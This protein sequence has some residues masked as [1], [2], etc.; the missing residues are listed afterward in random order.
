MRF[1]PPDRKPPTVSLQALLADPSKASIFTG[2][3][4]FV[5]VTAQTEHD[6]L[7]TPYSEGVPTNGIE[8][9]ADAFE[10]MAQ[11]LYITRR[12]RSS[13]CRCSRCCWWRRG[14]ALPLSAGM[15]GLRLRRAS[16]RAGGVGSRPTLA[17]TQRRVFSFT[18]SV[19]GGVAGQRSPRRRTITW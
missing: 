7:F 18:T 5:G 16:D 8:I 11:G 10:T 3:V 17:F 9:N 13:G 14:R 6:R 12:A 15:A 4:V 19:F 1:S 2:K